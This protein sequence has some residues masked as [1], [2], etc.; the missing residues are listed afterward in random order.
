MAGSAGCASWANWPERPRVI[1]LSILALTAKAF[2]PYGDVIETEGREHV[3]I[4]A[5]TAERYSDLAQVDVGAAGGR[6][7]IS[8]CRATPVG[9]PLRLRLME[10]HPL[11]SQAFVPLSRVPFLIVVAPPGEG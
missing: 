4:N 7:L 9:L 6:P 8:L 10:R 2:A 1:K 5:G 3:A 11:S